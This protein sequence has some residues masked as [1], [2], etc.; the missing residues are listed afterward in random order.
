MEVVYFI[1]DFMFQTVI[2]YLRDW[3]ATT[4]KMPLIPWEK[5]FKNITLKF[6]V[7]LN[8]KQVT[9]KKLKK[10]EKEYI[11]MKEQE[12]QQEDPIERM[13]VRCCQME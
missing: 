10:Y 7:C 12:M 13:E 3:C 1:L 6:Y 5:R 11:T 8:S 9:S 2:L 4:T